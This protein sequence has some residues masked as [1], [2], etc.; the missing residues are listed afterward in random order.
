MMRNKI[1]N[2]IYIYLVIDKTL[3]QKKKEG[4]CRIKYYTIFYRGCLK[5]IY[6]LLHDPFQPGLQLD[7]Q[8]WTQILNSNFK[9]YLSC[10]Q[11][12]QC[13]GSS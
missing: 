7:L 4:E 11:Q 1:I 5:I 3:F 6:I 8:C 9:S 13:I 10:F 2:A 12:L